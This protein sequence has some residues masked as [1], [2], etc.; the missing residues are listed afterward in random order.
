ML[1]LKTLIQACKRKNKQ[2]KETKNLAILDLDPVNILKKWLLSVFCPF[3]HTQ[4]AFYTENQAFKKTSSRV[5]N[6]GNSF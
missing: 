5:K 4:I 1:H 2:T 6:F 3:V